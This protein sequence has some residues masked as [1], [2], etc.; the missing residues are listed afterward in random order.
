MRGKDSSFHWCGAVVISRRH[1]LTA[2]HCLREFPLSTYL[3]RVGDFALGEPLMGS[4][5]IK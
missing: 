2:A 5:S 3:I 1:L 4:I